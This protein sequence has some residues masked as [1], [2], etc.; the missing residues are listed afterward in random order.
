MKYA[1][2]A[3]PPVVGGKVESVDG[4][5]AMKVPGV[6]KIVVDRGHAAAGE[7]PAA[8]RRRGRRP[9]YLGGDQGARRAQDRTGTTVR[10]PV[11]DFGRLQGAARRDRA[12]AGQG[13][14]QRGRRRDGARLGRQDRSAGVLHPALGACVDGAA[15]RHGRASPT[16]NARSGRRCRAPATPAT[17]WPRSSACKPEDVTVNVTLLGGG[18]GRKSKCDF[19]LEAAILSREMG[20]APVKVSWTREDDLQ[21]DY[22]HTVS[23]ERIDAGIDPQGRVIAW[24]HRSVAPT[25]SVDL[26]AGPEATSCRSSSA[27]GWSTCRSTS[28]TC[29][30][31][32]ARPRRIPGSAGSAR[33]RTS[34]TAFAV[35][36]FAAELA[37]ALGP[38][39]EGR[40][41]SS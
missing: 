15:V 40:C 22:L 16:A 37:D 39:S 13:R 35:Q 2:V 8:R 26:L 6:E 33:S 17:R 31:R 12:Q 36:S 20:G 11:Y 23:L 19:V 29:A 14:A 28:P 7:I 9:Q 1:V 21:H 27:W 32:T 38:G 10:T 5:A 4:S 25:I 34:R 18:F 3:R 24:R 30:A 41:C